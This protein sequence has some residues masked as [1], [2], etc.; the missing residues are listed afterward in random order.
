[1]P[2]LRPFLLA[3]PPSKSGLNREICGITGDRLARP[4]RD[5]ILPLGKW[6]KVRQCD[7]ET[8]RRRQLILCHGQSASQGVPAPTLQ[9]TAGFS[10]RWV[11]GDSD[12]LSVEALQE[13]R[14]PGAL[15]TQNND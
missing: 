1:M 7:P 14:Y 4:P 12:P 15:V 2:P 11:D 5:L 3:K 6:V 9:G 13:T 10:C 8:R